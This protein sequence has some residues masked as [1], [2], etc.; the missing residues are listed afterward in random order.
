M[1]PLLGTF[2]FK[3][4]SDWQ[5]ILNHLGFFWTL[6]RTHLYLALVAVLLGL[7]VALPVGRPRR[8]GTEVYGPI[9]VGHDGASTPC[10]PWPSSPSSSASPA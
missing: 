4:V 10:R 3:K 6:S 9:L 8:P 1:G 2:M 7:V 5:W